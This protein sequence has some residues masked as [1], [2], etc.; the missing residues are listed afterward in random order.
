MRSV[1]REV[2]PILQMLIIVF[3][4]KTNE[5]WRVSKRA[6]RAA[7]AAL[8]DE[9]TAPATRRYKDAERHT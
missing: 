4:N 6:R 1:L 7:E 2:L 5:D 8:A 3:Q 9:R